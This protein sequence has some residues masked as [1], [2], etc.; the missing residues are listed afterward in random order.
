MLLK[1]FNLKKQTK[2]F[3]IRHIY[4]KQFIVD[5]FLFLIKKLEIN[6][7]VSNFLHKKDFHKELNKCIFFT[8]RSLLSEIGNLIN[9]KEYPNIKLKKI[10]KKKQEIYFVK[11]SNINK[12]AENFLNKI[13]NNFI[14]VSGDSDTEIRI[15]DSQTDLKLKASIL[16]ILNNKK[17]I[18]WYSQNLFFDHHKTISLPH[19]LDYHTIWE[20]RKNWEDFRYSPSFQEKRLIQI[21][22]NSKHFN[23]RK[24][25]IF[26]NWHFSLNH[27]N[28][29]KIYE[30]INKK[31]NY[32]LENRITRFSNWE[33]QSRY[34]YIFCPSGK[35]LDDPRIYESIVLGNI[36]IRIEDQLSK[37]HEGLPIINIKSLDDLNL[38]FI[39]SK[40]INFDSQKFDFQKLFLDYWRKKLNLEYKHDTKDFENITI[41]KFRANIINF[42][43][44]N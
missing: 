16:K 44:N 3:V 31:D 9:Q 15:D 33:I 40:F 25:L 39:N 6:K 22:N 13:S 20:N 19:G 17:L 4:K 29:K 5:F 28:R 34:R 38:D 42:Y 12:F 2:D 11:S 24:N 23:D 35:G 36:P 7:S 14:L 10:N 21:L 41:M 43:I 8:T 32:F 37:F 1:S 30:T 26:N 18:N 27:G